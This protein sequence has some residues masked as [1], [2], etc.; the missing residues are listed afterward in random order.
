MNIK[1]R[2]LIRQLVLDH[3][4]LSSEPQKLLDLHYGNVQLEQPLL[5]PIEN[6]A[7]QLSIEQ[8]NFE[9]LDWN[10]ILELA[11]LNNITNYRKMKKSE[12]VSILTELQNE[13]R[14]TQIN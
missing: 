5:N 12:L 7:E 9:S 2:K 4:E 8:I 10:S 13:C 11:K 3:P 14:L 6:I 1:T